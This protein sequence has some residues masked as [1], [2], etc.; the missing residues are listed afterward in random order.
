MGCHGVAS[1]LIACQVR[2][3]DAFTAF[4]QV[5]FRGWNRKP[6]AYGA[7]AAAGL[8]GVTLAVAFCDQIPNEAS[9]KYPE[10]VKQYLSYVDITSDVAYCLHNDF[11]FEKLNA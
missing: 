6:F 11:S 10:Y 1:R 2:H 5:S 3:S 9:K 8:Q 7:T 4:E